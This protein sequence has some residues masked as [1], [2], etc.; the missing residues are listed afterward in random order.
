MISNLVFS[1]LHYRL[2]LVQLTR[3]APKDVLYVTSRPTLLIGLK[4][5][6]VMQEEAVA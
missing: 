1:V 4:N 5:E 2:Q 3:T 6:Q